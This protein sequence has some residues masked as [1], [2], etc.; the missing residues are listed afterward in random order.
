M[1]VYQHKCT[2]CPA[3]CELEYSMKYVGQENE[4]PDDTIKQ[5]S[6]NRSSCKSRQRHK[7]SFHFTQKIW[8]RIP[9]AS[10][11]ANVM[12]G[13]TVSESDLLKKKQDS[14]KARS[15]TH[16]KNE[17]LP[18]LSKQDQIAFKRSG[19]YD[20]IKGDHEKMKPK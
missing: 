9:F 12:G 3:K 15:R 13:V 11:I 17:V 14:R 8:P 6:C 10:H 7:M 18:T 20:N 19:K 4:L 1:P 16:F 5:I 2:N